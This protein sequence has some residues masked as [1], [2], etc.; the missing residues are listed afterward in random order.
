MLVLRSP[1]EMTIVE[2]FHNLILPREEICTEISAGFL[3]FKIELR[4]LASS[5]NMVLND[6]FKT[7]L[8]SRDLAEIKGFSFIFF[9]KI[10]E[11]F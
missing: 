4:K 1:G 8:K 10:K 2:T 5:K 9:C 11:D 7:D 3:D 6:F